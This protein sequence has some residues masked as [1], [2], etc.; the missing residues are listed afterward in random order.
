MRIL[1]LSSVASYGH[2]AILAGGVCDGGGSV[3]EAEAMQKFLSTGF[4]DARVEVNLDTQGHDT[5]SSA[6][7]LAASLSELAIT[8]THGLITNRSHMP[9]ALKIFRSSRIDVLPIEAELTL[10]RSGNREYE[11]IANDYL[12][13][14]RYF[15][16]LGKEAVMRGALLLDRQ[17]KISQALA[18]RLRANNF[19]HPSP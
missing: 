12:H 4:P 10:L 6:K 19:A 5:W 16:R 17:G 13:S 18:G 8:G 7:S 9:R 14:R 11:Q 3:T 1:A 15:V 2:S